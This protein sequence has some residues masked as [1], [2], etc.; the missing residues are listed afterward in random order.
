MV[1]SIS[2]QIISF[3]SLL[4][5]LVL[6]TKNHQALSYD[7]FTSS[8]K[9]LCESTPYPDVCFSNSSSSKM[10]NNVNI[11]IQSLKVAISEAN[12]VFNLLSNITN[13]NFQ[14]GQR[15]T[16]Q[17]CNELYEI[18]ISS[19][20]DSLIQLTSTSSLDESTDVS[21]FLAAAAT[22]TDTCLE[23]LESA[24]GPL[25]PLLVDA[26]NNAYKPLINSLSLFAN[27][28]VY[29]TKNTKGMNW[30]SNRKYLS[31]D[32]NINS[33]TVAKDGSGNFTT[34]MDAINFAPNRSVDKV[35]IN[36]N[37]GV[38]EEYIAI[39]KNKHNIILRGEGKGSTIISGNRNRIDGWH[40]YRSATV[41]VSGRGFMARDIGFRNV[42]GPEKEQAVLRV[43]A[44]FAALYRCSIRG[45]QDSLYVHSFTQFYRECDIYGTIDYIFGDATVVFQKC[46]I[47]TI[48]P[49]P[50]QTSTVITAQS[51]TYPFEKTGMSF[52]NC[53]IWAS[54]N[55]RQSSASRLIRSY[56]GRPWRAYARVVFI[57]SYIDGFI[58][59]EGWLPWGD[60]N[61]S[62]T[63]YYGEY[64]NIGSGSDIQGRVKWLGHHVMDENEASNFKV[65]KFIMGQK[66]L[67][68]TSFPYHG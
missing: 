51:R 23:E 18:T 7:N 47:T 63:V 30:L 55:L 21:T 14:E 40:T 11:L 67:D 15:G 13:D 19:L 44:E 56:L 36:I 31:H 28:N 8:I 20:N 6:F 68:S 35:I 62:D 54:K 4:L 60:K 37:K 24:S 42:A 10:Y 26:I 9:S 16:I 3:Q 2:K 12:K 50:E 17:D 33:I 64:G 41:G 43:N 57:E 38:Y 52:I 25:K 1:M 34:I 58:D 29:T 5:I 32:N 66:W 53:N 27:E 59:P 61:Y 45:Y 22:N 39:R 65:S 49:L 46:N 48:T